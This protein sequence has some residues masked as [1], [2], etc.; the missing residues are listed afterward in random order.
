MTFAERCLVFAASCRATRTR[1]FKHFIKFRTIPTR[2]RRRIVYGSDGL[3][4]FN[5]HRRIFRARSAE[6]GGDLSNDVGQTGGSVSMSVIE[7]ADNRLYPRYGSGNVGAGRIFSLNRDGSGEGNLRNFS[8]TV[9]SRAYGP[10]GMLYRSPSGIV[11]GT[12]EY[13]NLTPFYGT[14]FAIGAGNNAPPVLSNVGATSPV[15]EGGTTTLS[16]SISDANANDT[17]S[18]TVD[19]GDGSAPQVFNYPAGTTSF[20]ETHQYLDDN[21][22]GTPADNYQINLT[23]ADQNG[24]S[25]TIQPL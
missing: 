18:L 14:V 24:G 23:L 4:Y 3:L 10:Y 16:G 12:T 15:T 8:F 17:F 2:T 11:Y 1:S 9:G 22:T 5:N 19:W 6:S 7:G 13:T 20:S 25:D 21:P